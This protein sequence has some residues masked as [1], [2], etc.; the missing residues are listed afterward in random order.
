MGPLLA[1]PYVLNSEQLDMKL[2]AWFWDK[3]PK[4]F[5]G[6]N[7]LF[8]HNM[9]FRLHDQAVWY[10][11]RPYPLIFIESR[12]KMVRG[13]WEEN[14]Q[15]IDEALADGFD[16]NA[17]A[18]LRRGI[19]AYAL[20]AELD[21]LEVLHYLELK[22]AQPECISNPSSK[23]DLTP[24]MMAVNSWNVR[25]VEYL[26]ERGSNPNVRD[27]YGLSAKDKALIKN[28]H[29][30]SN[31]LDNYE[32]NYNEINTSKKVTTK[33]EDEK[34]VLEYEKV[35]VRKAENTKYMNTLPSKYKNFA[36]HP[37]AEMN[38]SGHVLKLFDVERGA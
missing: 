16:I 37:F 25:I 2:P 4:T 28:L 11:Y 33:Y 12:Y 14:Y 18:D 13:V 6:A 34:K 26:V 35:L 23:Y 30:I 31:I 22:G 7:L 17:P 5:H 3:W 19:N 29:T 8:L 21:K 27:A 32:Q 10:G 1:M 20:A 38:Q 9:I 15:L 36:T 24:L